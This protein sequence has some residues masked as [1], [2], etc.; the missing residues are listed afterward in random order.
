VGD[1][2]IQEQDK[3]QK[4]KGIW[5]HKEEPLNYATLFEKINENVIGF[6]PFDHPYESVHLGG[7]GFVDL[8]NPE[9]DFSGYGLIEGLLQN[10][11]SPFGMNALKI[12]LDLIGKGLA[13]KIEFEIAKDLSKSFPGDTSIA[14]G[15]SSDS[16]KVYCERIGFV[17]FKAMPLSDYV[18][19]LDR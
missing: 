18:R 15:A 9:V 5:I 6:I 4:V 11:F 3:F 1:S 8:S 17:P 19:L 10:I 7:V 12:K 16:H 13:R 14:I 2:T